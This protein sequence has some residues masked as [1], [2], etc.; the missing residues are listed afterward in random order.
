M[1]S[2]A[3]VSMKDLLEGMCGINIPDNRGANI[4]KWLSLFFGVLSFALIFIVERLGSVLEVSY[5][6][7]F[8]VINQQ[9][10]LLLY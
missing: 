2:L 8:Q 6:W 7:L 4:S 1:N 9:Y 3:A 10:S 5:Y